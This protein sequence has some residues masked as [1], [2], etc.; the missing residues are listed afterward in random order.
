VPDELLGEAI[1]AWI[2]RRDDGAPGEREI[3][4]HCDGRLAA[5]KIP[6]ALHFVA[7]LPKNSFG[8]VLKEELRR[9]SRS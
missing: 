1:E 2:V 4:R 5:F 9:S 7:S 6:R 3:L 8:K